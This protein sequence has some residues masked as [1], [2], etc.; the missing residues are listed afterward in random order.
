MM[1]NLLILYLFSLA[2]SSMAQEL[3]FKQNSIVGKDSLQ[4]KRV[5][6]K[7]FNIKGD[8]EGWS[9]K[10]ITLSKKGFK[11][12]YADGKDTIVAREPRG[13]MAYWQTERGISI[14]GMEDHLVSLNYDQPEEW[15]RFP[16]SPK[17]TLSGE[18]SGSGLYCKQIPIQRHGIYTTATERIGKLELP[19][20]EELKDVI[21]LHTERQI[22]DQTENEKMPME[23]QHY[24]WYVKGYRYPIIEVVIS[25]RAGQKFEEVALYCPLEEQEKLDSDGENKAERT[26]AVDEAITE[27]D[28]GSG[29]EYEINNDGNGISVDYRLQGPAKIVALLASNQGYV[30]Q[31]RELSV[32]AG[33][34]H[35]DINT[36][37]LRRG[38]YVVYLNVNGK[39]HAEKVNLK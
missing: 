5:S 33:T 26:R 12:K 1:R 8:E 27:Y 32:P 11:I 21:C 28:D 16:M 24:R 23:Q 25:S 22:T 19:D 3:S 34:G 39:D 2:L 30:Y 15:L 35:F 13:R 9:L 18:F 14:I 37:G 6:L 20:G 36:N 10:D 31:R 7:E 4:L 17:D 38:Q 29:F